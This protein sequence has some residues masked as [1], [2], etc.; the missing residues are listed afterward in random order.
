LFFAASALGIN[1]EMV[2]VCLLMFPLK[3][4]SPISFHS[5]VSQSQR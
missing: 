1:I 5:A 3:P 2:L 4:Q